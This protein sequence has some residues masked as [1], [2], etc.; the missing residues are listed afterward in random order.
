MLEF[1]LNRLILAPLLLCA[2]AASSNQAAQFPP[3]PV[4]KGPET[5]QPGDRKWPDWLEETTKRLEKSKNISQPGPEIEFL[6]AR[7]TEL[8]ERAMGSRDNFFRFGRFIAAA[9]AV[10]EAS[11]RMLWLRK[12]ERMPQQQDYWG[13]GFILPGC[14]FRVRQAE[15]FASLTNEKNAEQYV[16]WS[17]SF[18]QQARVAYDAHEY[19]R[20]RLY[21]DASYSIVFA[22]ECIAQATV[23]VP[24]TPNTK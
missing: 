11:D 24:E 1:I 5:W 20:S 9:N 2:V 19:Q 23:Q 12:V 21:G 16:T 17:K 15:F 18:Y 6:N 14:Y 4:P 7:A 3:M 8:L 13:A 10:L 22:L